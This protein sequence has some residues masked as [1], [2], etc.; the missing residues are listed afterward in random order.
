MHETHVPKHTAHSFV[1]K[2]P[3]ER[4]VDGHGDDEDTTTWLHSA[5]TTTTTRGRGKR[6]TLLVA[7]GFG[8][9]VA[10]GALGL[11]DLLARLPVAFG[12]L[13]ERCHADA[14]DDTG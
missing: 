9:A 2:W 13:S 12:R 4:G 8:D 10:L 7:F 3:T 5:T 6:R 1:T 14:D 11:E